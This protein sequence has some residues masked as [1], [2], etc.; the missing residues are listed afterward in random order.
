MSIVRQF[1]EQGYAERI[2]PVAE[3][4]CPLPEAVETMSRWSR[5]G[6]MTIFMAGVFDLPT[7][8]H[9]F[10]L[11]E[12]RLMGGAIVRGIDYSSLTADSASEL[13]EGVWEAAASDNVKLM[14]SVDTDDNVAR[15]KAFRP[16]KGNSPKPIFSWATRAYNLASYTV[17]QHGGGA[18]HNTV[19]YV[20]THGLNACCIHPNCNSGDNALMVADLQPRLVV[21]NAASQDTVNTVLDLKE[22]GLIPNTEIGLTSEHVHQ[23]T[24]SLIGDRVSSTSI[25]RRARGETTF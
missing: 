2:E 19:D 9:R 16:D 17:P 11:A 18:Y 13:I 15:N 12:A 3:G 4:T 21:I 14:V 20:T 22:R 23:Y 1:V 6:A 10:G 24:D 5:A 7:P 8:N 25:I